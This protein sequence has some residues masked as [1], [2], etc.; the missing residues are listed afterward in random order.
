MEYFVKT[1]FAGRVDPTSA[2][3]NRQNLRD[4]SRRFFWVTGFAV[5]ALLA[6]SLPAAAETDP[7]EFIGSLGN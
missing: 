3:V 7:A 4:I 6:Q 5:F 2:D 1:P